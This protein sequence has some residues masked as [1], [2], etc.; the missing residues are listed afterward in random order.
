MAL[1]RE[2]D[3]TRREEQTRR[4]YDGVFQLRIIPDESVRPEFP[5]KS[6]IDLYYDYAIQYTCSSHHPYPSPLG[7]DGWGAR[8]Y[9]TQLKFPETKSTQYCVDYEQSPSFL[10][11]SRASETR[12]R[13]K[14]TPREKRRHLSI[15]GHPST[16]D[17]LDMISH[18]NQLRNLLH[19]SQV[20][21]I[22]IDCNDGSVT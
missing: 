9:N 11:D 13:V 12:A 22:P 10:R 16:R 17:Q 3:H 21:R 6:S 8:N 1:D 19:S 4:N 7:M 2:N 20:K 5:K 14:I 15:V 18:E